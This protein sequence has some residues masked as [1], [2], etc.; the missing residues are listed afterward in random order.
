MS[1]GMSGAGAI[2]GWNQRLADDLGHPARRPGGPDRFTVQQDKA[3]IR[4]KRGLIE[5]RNIYAIPRRRNMTSMT[6]MTIRTW[7]QLPVFGKLGLMFP[8]KKPSNHRISRITMIVHNMRFLLL[9]D[10]LSMIIMTGGSIDIRQLHDLELIDPHRVLIH[11][12]THTPQPHPSPGECC[13]P[14]LGG[15]DEK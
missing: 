11:H 7:I 12:T 8:P 10:S 13:S 2:C 6:T 5:T 3:V 14:P 9:S 15:D 4:F 1:T